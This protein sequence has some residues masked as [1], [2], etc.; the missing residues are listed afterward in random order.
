MVVGGLYFG[1]GG[2]EGEMREG[3]RRDTAGVVEW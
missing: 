3:E 1:G 2:R